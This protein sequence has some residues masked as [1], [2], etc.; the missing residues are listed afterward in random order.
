MTKKKQRFCVGRGLEAGKNKTTRD[1]MGKC[2]RGS[3]NR[4]RTQAPLEG[5]CRQLR[6]KVLG[7]LLNSKRFG[8]VRARTSVGG[9]IVEEILE[10]LN[11]VQ[12]LNFEPI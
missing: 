7:L 11:V 9:L 10:G 3:Q 2:G 5:G 1:W 4:E 8:D 6:R 12:G